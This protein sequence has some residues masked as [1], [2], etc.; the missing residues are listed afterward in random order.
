[1]ISSDD[2]HPNLAAP[3]IPPNPH[4][5]RNKDLRTGLFKVK[6]MGFSSALIIRDPGY[7]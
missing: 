3:P 5:L 4:H 6:P 7:F 2:I 1:V